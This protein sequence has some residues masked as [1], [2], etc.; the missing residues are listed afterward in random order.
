MSA[1]WIINATI[2]YDQKLDRE[3][4][5]FDFETSYTAW[6]FCF[7]VAISTNFQTLAQSFLRCWCLGIFT[8]PSLFLSITLGTPRDWSLR[9]IVPW[10]LKSFSHSIFHALSYYI[11]SLFSSIPAPSSSPS[12][13]G[14]EMAVIALEGNSCDNYCNKDIL[15]GGQGGLSVVHP[16]SLEG[17]VRK[18]L[19]SGMNRPESK[20]NVWSHLMTPHPQPQSQRPWQ[21]KCSR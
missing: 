11:T 17:E 2:V 18:Y 6:S 15:V 8:S 13:M 14:V 7:C 1:Y 12:I 4:L 16:T 19:L 5:C 20:Q 9:W 21:C 3:I 10:T